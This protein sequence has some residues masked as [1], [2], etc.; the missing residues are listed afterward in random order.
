VVIIVVV[1][2]GGGG[3]MRRRDGAQDAIRLPVL[4]FCT[5]ISDSVDI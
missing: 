3:G 4:S 2:V 5:T 1:V